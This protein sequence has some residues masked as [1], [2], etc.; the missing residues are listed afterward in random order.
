MSVITDLRNDFVSYQQLALLYE[1]HADDFIEEIPIELRS[2]F[3]ANMASALGAVLDKLINGLNSVKFGHIDEKIKLILQKNDFL[4]FYGF[5]RAIDNHSTTIRYMKLR[6]SD[7]KFFSQYVTNELLNR[8]ELPRLSAGLKEKMT[9]AIYEIFVNAQIHSQTEHIYTCGQF[10]PIKNRIEFTITD[11]GIGFKEKIKQ[12]FGKELTSVQAIRWA[13]QDRHTTKKEVT[14]GI[15][16]AILRE[17]IIRNKGK[18][19]IVSG[20]GFYEYSHRG[21]TVETMTARFPGSIV[22]LQFC[23]D[24]NLSYLLASEANLKEIF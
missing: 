23:T 5:L 15:G 6:P 17:F 2:W 3:S 20:D 19:Q 10:Y 18:M 24:D 11:V 13:V 21:E 9:E 8:S 14:G 4:S 7:G 22:N 1:R 12:R 16:L